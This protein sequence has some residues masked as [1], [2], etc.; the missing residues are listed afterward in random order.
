MKKC[1]NVMIVLAMVVGV[2]S[3]SYAQDSQERGPKGA[4]PDFS[5]IDSNNSGEIDFDEF[6]AQTLPHGDHQT[7]F[8][9]IDADGNGV[10]SEQEFSDHKPPRPQ[11]RQ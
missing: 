5:S 1:V 9:D 3:Q 10:I 6:S 2:T 7:V 11:Q 4:R 8:D